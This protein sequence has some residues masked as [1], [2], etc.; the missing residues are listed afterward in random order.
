[1]FHLD[2]KARMYRLSKLRL[3]PHI[4]GQDISKVFRQ[5]YSGDVTIVPHISL[6][7]NFKVCTTATLASR[8]VSCLVRHGLKTVCACA[9]LSVQVISHPDDEDMRR[10]ILEG[11]RRYQHRSM[12]FWPHHMLISLS[13]MN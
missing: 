3:I 12:H 1:M 13:L 10:Y 7:D 11:E 4:F 5:K 2:L 8:G 9:G 6:F